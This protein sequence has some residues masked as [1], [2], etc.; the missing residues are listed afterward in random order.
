MACIL[1][2]LTQC[3]L[4]MVDPM[5]AT[6]P[7]SKGRSEIQARRD[8]RGSPGVGEG[9]AFPPHPTAS[10]PRPSLQDGRQV[11]GCKHITSATPTPA[12]H[13]APPGQ[14]LSH[15]N[16][17]EISVSTERSHCGRT[18]SARSA[19]S[20]PTVCSHPYRHLRMFS[21]E[22]VSMKPCLH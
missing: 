8:R 6:V 10:R 15:A 14:K 5:A 19:L 16:P 17:A 20:T 12:L 2:V 7:G 13:A 18:R 4:M 3:C 21:S 9:E 22:H 1:L 11:S